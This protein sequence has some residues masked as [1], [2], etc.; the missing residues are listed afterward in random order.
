MHAFLV[1]GGTKE[2][3]MN[4]VTK[5]LNDREVSAFDRMVLA[6]EEGTLGV[7]SVRDFTKRLSLAPFQGTLLAGI[8]EDAHRLTVEAQNALLKTLEEPGPKSMLYL[9]AIN[10]DVLLPTIA[11]RCQVISLG[12][13]DQ[14]TQDDLLQCFKTLKQMID[15]RP[16]ERI[17]LIDAIAPDRDAAKA[18]VER[19]IASA[20]QELVHTGGGLATPPKESATQLI[21]RLLLAQRQLSANVTPKLV[22][23]AIF[24]NS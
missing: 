20:H 11:S 4:W 15:A 3:R 14:Y 10:A 8:I 17:K 7:A 13:T 21:R 18:W 19:A 2:S 12:A 23:D 9:S 24:F 6:S 1:T 16:G 5:T 22:F